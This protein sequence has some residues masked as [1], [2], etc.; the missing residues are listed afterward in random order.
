MA[1]DLVIRG[2]RVVTPQGVG[3]WDVGILGERIAAV[4][5]AGT[6]PTEA[7]RV[8]PWGDGR[9]RALCRLPPRR[10][11]ASGSAPRRNTHPLRRPGRFRSESPCFSRDH[12]FARWLKS[13]ARNYFSASRALEFRSLRFLARASLSEMVQTAEPEASP[14]SP[15]LR[16]NHR[17]PFSL[18]A[19]LVS[20]HDLTRDAVLNPQDPPGT[21][22]TR[23]GVEAGLLLHSVSV[24]GLHHND[25]P[26]RH[27]RDLGCRE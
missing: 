12:V 10:G 3:A 1:L 15:R 6:L 16:Q 22:P 17:P 13:R 4:A 25:V 27:P 20:S 26:S 7:A 2:G 19:P 18:P 5:E 24:A 23:T 14:R 11:S 9:E 21:A 8:P